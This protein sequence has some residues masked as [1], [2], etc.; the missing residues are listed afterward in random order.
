[1]TGPK[2]CWAASCKKLF[3]AVYLVCYLL[4]LQC[5]YLSTVTHTRKFLHAAEVISELTKVKGEEGDL[6]QN[7]SQFNCVRKKD[8]SK[9]RIC[10]QHS[11]YHVSK[12]KYQLSTPP[13]FFCAISAGWNRPSWM[14]IDP[15]YFRLLLKQKCPWNRLQGVHRPGPDKW[16]MDPITGGPWTWSKI[17]GPCPQ[18]DVLSSPVRKGQSKDKLQNSKFK[19][20]IAH[21]HHSR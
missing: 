20:R 12:R 15:F 11:V 2:V 18:V 6:I 16:S 13:T 19:K 17:G 7:E 21:F 9:K 4:C 8:N 10:H 3:W 14:L 5:V 1:M